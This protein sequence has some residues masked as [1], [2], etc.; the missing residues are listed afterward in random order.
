MIRWKTGRLNQQPGL[1][2][3]NTQ[4][5]TIVMVT[6]SDIC[7][8]NSMRIVQFLDGDIIG[9]KTPGNGA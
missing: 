4:G 6:H 3:L 8:S 2:D 1:V 9:E 5:T 7:E